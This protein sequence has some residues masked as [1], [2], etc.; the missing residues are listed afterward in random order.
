M[1][2][3]WSEPESTGLWRAVRWYST[4]KFGTV[5]EPARVM[6]H[7]PRVLKAYLDYERAAQKWD[8]V[9]PALK[10]LAVMAAAATVGCSWCI[11][12]S[13]WATEDR[14]VPLDKARA[15]GRWREAEC[16]S[17]LERLVIEYAEAMSSTPAAVDAGLVERLSQHLAEDQLVELTAAIALENL[18]SR[19]NR[20]FGLASQG[21]SDRCEL[22]PASEEQPA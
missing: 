12:F 8:R 10:H 15:L 18:R 1:E 9:D 11:D 3:T 7:Q 22:A 2:R 4:R 6:A 16:F 5:L 13:Y 17:E 19:T 14:G 20:A 21:F